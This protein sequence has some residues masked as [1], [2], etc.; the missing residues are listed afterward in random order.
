MQL[1][2]MFPLAL[3][4]FSDAICARIVAMRC[5]AVVQDQCRVVDFCGPAPESADPTSQRRAW[6]VFSNV[7][8][9]TAR[10]LLDFFQR[11]SGGSVGRSTAVKT[12]QMQCVQYLV[13]FE[14]RDLIQSAI[15]R[16]R[17]RETARDSLITESTVTQWR[18]Q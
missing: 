11:S 13:V 6:P 16:E 12:V 2:V 4:H 9:D 14:W 10:E 17:E 1:T 3:L 7:L 8:A 18:T 5:N 15:E